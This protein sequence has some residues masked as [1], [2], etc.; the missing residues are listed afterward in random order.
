MLIGTALIATL[1]LVDF[2]HNTNTNNKIIEED[3]DD[4][5]NEEIEQMELDFNNKVNNYNNNVDIN[6]VYD[7]N[8]VIAIKNIKL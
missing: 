4:F 8:E 5:T 2:N 6:Y 7:N 1:F 3:I